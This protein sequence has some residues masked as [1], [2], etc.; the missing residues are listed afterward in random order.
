ML[1]KE[2]MALRETVS[3]IDV[4]AKAGLSKFQSAFE[5]FLD[6]ED[7]EVATNIT[8][9]VSSYDKPDISY[10][11]TRFKNGSIEM[12]IV[13][14][15]TGLSNYEP[16]EGNMDEDSITEFKTTLSFVLKN[17]DPKA[18][19]VD[20]LEGI[21]GKVSQGKNEITETFGDTKAWDRGGWDDDEDDEDDEDF[22]DPSG[23]R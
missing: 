9:D 4:T 14:A 10:S 13:V 18:I 12:D 19:P 17:V 3:T 11:A 1:I 8:G 15:G 6:D 16:G 20:G 23:D 21:F 22:D 5:D 7:N 2:L